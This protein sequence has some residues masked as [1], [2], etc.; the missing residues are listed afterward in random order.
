M[1]EYERESE[2]EI[3]DGDDDEYLTKLYKAKERRR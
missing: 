2:R 3:H 1:I